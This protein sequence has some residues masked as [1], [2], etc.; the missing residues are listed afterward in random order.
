MTRGKKN[1]DL[2]ISENKLQ[3]DLTPDIKYCT[4]N[5]NLWK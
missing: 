2:V 3:T 4:E 1:K 5:S